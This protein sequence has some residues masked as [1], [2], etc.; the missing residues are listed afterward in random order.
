MTVDLR[1]CRPDDR[2]RCRNGRVIRYHGRSDNDE[3]PN[4]VMYS[5]GRVGPRT[6]DGLTY[7]GNICGSDIVEILGQEPPRPRLPP[8][9]WSVTRT[10][11]CRLPL[12]VDPTIGPESRDH[13]PIHIEIH[14]TLQ[15]QDEHGV[16]VDVPEV[17]P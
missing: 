2:L 14:R 17:M 11:A 15:Y 10:T 1:K 8:L 13:L 3:Y 6:D 7:L 4:E 9:R 5:D 12:G 16:W